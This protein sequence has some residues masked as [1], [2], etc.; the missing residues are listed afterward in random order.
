MALTVTITQVALSATNDAIAKG[1]ERHGGPGQTFGGVTALVGDER[2]VSLED[3]GHGPQIVFQR[4]AKAQEG[5]GAVDEVVPPPA[6]VGGLRRAR[7]G[8]SAAP[9]I[10]VAPVS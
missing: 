4:A 10:S 3:D 7:L 6:K 5:V 1:G 8:V 2:L 9:Q